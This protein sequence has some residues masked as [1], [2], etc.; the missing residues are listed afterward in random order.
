M[1][2]FGC[3]VTTLFAHFQIICAETGAD[4]TF[5]EGRCVWRGDLTSVIRRPSAGDWGA[6]VTK[7]DTRSG[8]WGADLTFCKGRYT[9]A[10]WGCF[11]LLF[12]LPFSFG[13]FVKFLYLC[14]ASRRGLHHRT[15]RA[16]DGRF[17]GT[18]PTR[19]ASHSYVLG[20]KAGHVRGTKCRH[21]I[22]K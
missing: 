21:L 22:N 5:C 10:W 11:F 15:F 2:V 17:L 8:D 9:D 16:Q 12:F 7:R 19:F 14:S 3:K 4:L 1:F 6:D 20:P 13:R 18:R